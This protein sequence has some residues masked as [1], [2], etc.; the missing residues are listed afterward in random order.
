MSLSVVTPSYASD[1]VT[2]GV[3]LGLTGKYAEMSD[4]QLKGFRLW[5]KD[6]NKRGGILG[7]KVLLIVHDNKSSAQIAISDYEN[8]IEKEQVGFVF[9]PYSSEVTEAV[10]P[11][12]E[13][14]EYPLLISGASADSIW[15]KGYKNAFGIYT[16]AGKYTS[17]FL[18]M[19]VMNNLDDIAIISA[20]DSFSKDIAEG[21]KKWAVR[22]GLN[23]TFFEEFK[24]NTKDFSAIIERVKKSRS[25]VIIV[26]GHLEEAINT[27]LALKASGWF[28]K[29]FFASVGPTLPVYHNKL[30]SDADYVFSSSQ[31]E[32]HGGITPKG[33]VHFYESFL[34]AYKEKPSYHAATAYA[35]GQLM[36]EAIKKAGTFDRKKL[37]EIFSAMDIITIIGRYGVDRTG[38]QVKHFNLIVQWQNGEKE[39]VW[40]SELS[41]AKPI[42]R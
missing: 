13:K 11:V 30:L 29:A 27:R 18:E 8:L 17:G 16:P 38:M 14:Y 42:F 21:T 23:I 9:S 20:D 25:K 41:S 36:E 6:V 19:L 10:L 31:W 28:P 3:S 39:V 40:P 7:K 22:F 32:H 34:D 33:C 5:E 15:G 26:C 35:A 2:I 4:M 12:T 24:K 1:P 37:R